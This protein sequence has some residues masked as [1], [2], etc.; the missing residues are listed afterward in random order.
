MPDASGME[1]WAIVP[2]LILAAAV[3]ILLPLGSFL[4]HSR[5]DVATLVAAAALTAAAIACVPMLRWQPQAVFLDTYAVDPLAVFIKLFA[6]AGTAATLIASRGY[7]RDAPQAGAVPALLTL[8]C[9]GVIGLAASQDLALIALFVQL[10][11]VG[12]YILA[13]IVKD[14]RRATEA[15]LK[16]FL[17]AATAGAVMLYGMSLLYGLTGTLRLPELGARLPQRS[18]AVVVGLA[19]LLAGYGFKITLV[20]FHAW[21]PDTY[22]GA[23]TPIAGFLTVVPKAAA[24]VVLL[25]T[26]AVS[27]H[28]NVVDWPLLL[29]IVAALTMTFGNLLALR[30]TSAKRLLAYS[31][32]AQAGYLLVGVA[33][34]RADALA[35]P[36][37]LFYLVVY[38]FMNLGAFLAVA[39]V[40]RH[41][42]TDQLS[43][44]S[45]VGRSRPSIG[46]CLTLCLLSLAGLPPFGGFAAK[47]MLFGAALGAG[48]TAL[49]LL[50][51]ANSALSL[52]FYLRMIQPMY[53]EDAAARREAPVPRGLPFALALLTAGTLL[54]GVLPQPW[55]AAAGV[56]STL[57]LGQPPATLTPR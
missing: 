21:A 47:T 38:L 5:K 2:E 25:R 41:V 34:A 54:S 46:G 36:G 53:F 56:A 20:P 12:S 51:A 57:W 31:S 14:D 42:G 37:L 44:F 26:L 24:F 16:L 4:S 45:G 7:F 3:L 1:L 27:F 19:L 30:Q 17:F 9:L 32:I 28:V 18:L 52:F 8:T 10:V 11:S 29:A 43:A 22:Q 35:M 15:A 50:M 23:P 39:I 48:W 33:A 55:I 49:A 6:I 40:E 13:G